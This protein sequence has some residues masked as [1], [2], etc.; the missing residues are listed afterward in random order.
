[1][2]SRPTRTIRKNKCLQKNKIRRENAIEKNKSEKAFFRVL[3]TSIIVGI[4][5]VVCLC[6]TTWAWF[7]GSIESQKNEIKTGE[8]KMEITL[9]K[10]GAQVTLQ[11]ESAVLNEGS[12][13]VTLFLPK[14]S[15]SG[16]CMI[17]VGEVKYFSQGI[18]RHEEEAGKS[19]SFTVTVTER[20]TVKFVVRWGIYSGT[21]EV[22]A[23][24][25]LAV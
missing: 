24:E 17:Q 10:E 23:G 9:E 15:A 2:E 13:L 25:I 4:L 6:S 12:Y 5:C 19:L 14:D 16:Y 22:R 21:P 7:T 1:M 18:L 20:K 8:C 3:Y 11:G